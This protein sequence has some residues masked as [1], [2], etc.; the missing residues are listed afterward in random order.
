MTSAN[1]TKRNSFSN[2]FGENVRRLFCTCSI[3]YDYCYCYCYCY[4]DNSYSYSSG[5][6]RIRISFFHVTVCTVHCALYAYCVV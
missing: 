2:N 3:D 6:C 4:Y 5:F 1:L